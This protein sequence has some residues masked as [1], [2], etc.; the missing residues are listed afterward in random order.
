MS[1]KGLTPGPVYGRRM[2]SELFMQRKK[3][4]GVSDE[5]LREGASVKRSQLQEDLGEEHF[6][7]QHMR[8]LGIGMS[9]QVCG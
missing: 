4:H 6:R 8:T 9:W 5:G 1:E 3:E 2:T 7:A